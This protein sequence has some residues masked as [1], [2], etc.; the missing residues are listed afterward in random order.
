M[1]DEMMRN[2]TRK[3]WYKWSFYFNIVLFFIVA[4]FLYLLIVDSISYGRGSGSDAWL[5]ITRDVAFIAISLSLIF[6]QFIR[7]LFLIMRRAL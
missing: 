2:V 7:N 4:L 5:Y 6:A 1:V 3:T